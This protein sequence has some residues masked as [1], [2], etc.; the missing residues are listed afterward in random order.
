MGS[1][2]ET[3]IRSIQVMNGYLKVNDLCAFQ[4]IIIQNNQYY[5]FSHLEIQY[6]NAI[7]F[8]SAPWILLRRKYHPTCTL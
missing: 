5:S 7:V 1:G 4:L 2:S 3:R 6:S 8:P